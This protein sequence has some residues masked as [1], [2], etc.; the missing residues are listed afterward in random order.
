MDDLCI[1]EKNFLKTVI[2]DFKKLL[3]FHDKGFYGALHS[4]KTYDASVSG[5]EKVTL[6]KTGTMMYYYYL[7]YKEPCPKE[8]N[9]IQQ[10]QINEIWIAMGMPENVVPV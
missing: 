4:R 2:E 1:F 8:P 9:I 3:V 6:S 5:A 10:R 7:L